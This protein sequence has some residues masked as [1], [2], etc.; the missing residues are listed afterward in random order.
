MRGQNPVQRRTAPQRWCAIWVCLLLILGLAPH[1]HTAPVHLGPADTH[2]SDLEPAHHD[3]QD[4]V[5][6]LTHCRS[7]SSCSYLRASDP[8]SPRLRPNAVVLPWPTVRLK[9]PQ[10]IDPLFRPPKLPTEA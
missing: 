1:G 9:P 8:V 2:W 3:P 6:T 5:S 4:D 7:G 10:I